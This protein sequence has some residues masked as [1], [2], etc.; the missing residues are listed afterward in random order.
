MGGRIFAEVCRRIDQVQQRG[1]S[2]DKG[3]YLVWLDHIDRSAALH[4]HQ[5]KHY[6]DRLGAAWRTEIG[7]VLYYTS[8][9]DYSAPR[10]IGL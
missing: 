5:C 8:K 2:G 9:G 3:R 10:N 6:D 1:S 4:L 7:K